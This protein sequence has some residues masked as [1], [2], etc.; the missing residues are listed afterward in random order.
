[1]YSPAADETTDD[2]GSELEDVAETEGAAL[3]LDGAEE[4]LDV[5]PLSGS[6]QRTNVLHWAR[7]IV[8]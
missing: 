4:D 5:A 3:I 8:T 2:L 6:T 7:A 1:M